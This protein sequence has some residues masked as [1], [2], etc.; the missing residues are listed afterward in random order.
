MAPDDVMIDL[1]DPVVD[2]I[3]LERL[4]KTLEKP[5]ISSP[6]H[7]PCEDAKG[8]RGSFLMVVGRPR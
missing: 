6:N 3:H 8:T 1:E 5:D 7:P 2:S 4:E